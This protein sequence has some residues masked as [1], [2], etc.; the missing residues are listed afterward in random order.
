MW[1]SRCTPGVAQE[2]FQQYLQNFSRS[3][4]V[5][6]LLSLLPE[7]LISSGQRGFVSFHAR[8]ALLLWASISRQFPSA[9]FACCFIEHFEFSLRILSLECLHS[10]PLIPQA[11]WVFACSMIPEA[12]LQVEEREQDTSFPLLLGGYP[13]G[14]LFQYILCRERLVPAAC[15]SG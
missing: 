2:M 15:K 5:T 14:K 6:S 1:V 3:L 11:Q 8:L 9:T 13:S 10:F 7:G 12:W 4:W